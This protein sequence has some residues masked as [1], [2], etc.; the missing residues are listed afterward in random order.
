MK[1][2][3]KTLT[4]LFGSVLG[5]SLVA[6]SIVTVSCEF[7]DRPAPDEGNKDN[8]IPEENNP[9]FNT[10]EPATPSDEERKIKELDE[11]KKKVDD[12]TAAVES[13]IQD[14]QTNIESLRK[15]LDDI[16]VE[17][18]RLRRGLERMKIRKYNA[19]LQEAWNFLIAELEALETRV[20]ESIVEN[21]SKEKLKYKELIE[22]QEKYAKFQ[23]EI[24]TNTEDYQANKEKV[25]EILA[26]ITDELQKA[27]LAF[28]EL[29]EQNYSEQLQEQFQSTID[30]L[31]ALE[32]KAKY[33]LGEDK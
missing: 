1:E 21:D 11:T 12:L 5:V 6:S 4:L 31:E 19:Q 22:L 27:K 14:P 20:H 16:K 32:K 10:D 7:T 30:K 18:Q 29:K 26:Q 2:T 13:N 9:D 28:N 8:P 15:A 23:S 25:K 17:L 33:F 3:K 24:K